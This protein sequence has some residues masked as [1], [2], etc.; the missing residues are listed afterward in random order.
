[1]VEEQHLSENCVR[2]YTVH[3]RFEMQICSA[4]WVLS[5]DREM[6]AGQA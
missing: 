3:T 5:F 4:V 1:V 6:E 2:V